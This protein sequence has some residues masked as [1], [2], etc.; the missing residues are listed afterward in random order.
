VEVFAVN[1]AVSAAAY[2]V[3]DCDADTANYAAVAAYHAANY[4][5]TVAASTA[6]NYAAAVASAADAANAAAYAYH[7]AAVAGAASAD[8]RERQLDA[9]AFLVK[10]W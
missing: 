4:A 1:C 8:E 9:I 7:A 6:A 10:N 3:N 5:A 2:R